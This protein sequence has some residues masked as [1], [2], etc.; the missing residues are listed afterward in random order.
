MYF[1]NFFKLYF[2]LITPQIQYTSRGFRGRSVGLYHT[3]S[4]YSIFPRMSGMDVIF[5]ESVRSQIQ[6]FEST[7]IH[8]LR[9]CNSLDGI[10][11]NI[12]SE[13]GIYV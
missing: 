11:L 2:I 8:M 7:K 6:N 13:Y 4:R 10:D 3:R 1:N 9:G 12:D 5:Y